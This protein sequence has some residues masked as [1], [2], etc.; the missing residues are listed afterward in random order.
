MKSIVFFPYDFFLIGECI[1]KPGR[2]PIIYL[3][4]TEFINSE[5]RET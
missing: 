2:I 4:P 1:M 3:I 5:K